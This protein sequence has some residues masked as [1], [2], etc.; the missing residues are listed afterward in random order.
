[1]A[2]SSLTCW[3]VIRA[4][5]GGEADDRARFAERYEP[6]IRGY[7]GA[8]WRSSP[9]LAE[10]DDATQEVFVE[11]FK[12]G[13]ALDRADPG[14]GA[15][16]AFLYGVTRNVA[17]R[18][19]QAWCRRERQP[20]SRVDAPELDADAGRMFERAWAEALMAQARALQSARASA[21]KDGALTRIEIL[22]LRFEEGLPVREIAQHLQMDAARAH[23]E[24]A[25][26]RDEFRQALI[27]VVREHEAVGP[28]DAEA[29]CSR[30][31]RS[32]H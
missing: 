16:R 8:R 10:V 4:A 9:L 32:L 7:L 27:D 22:R 11:C 5:A 17:R 20:D 2:E 18:A 15:F 3:T 24:Y 1:M 25:K 28:R 12:A 31:V 30:L 6:A 19:E 21:A 26:A 14:R 23:H 29:E 13:G